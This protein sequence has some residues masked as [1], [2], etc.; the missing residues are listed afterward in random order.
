[1]RIKLDE[2]LPQRLDPA[3]ASLGHEVDTVVRE[4]LQGSE[5]ETLWPEVQA[6]R[7]FL[8]TTDLDFSDERRFPPGTHAGILVLRLSDD[9]SQA[10]TERLAAVFA[11]ES[12]ETWSGCLVI[13]TD[14]KVRVRRPQPRASS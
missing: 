10:V 6:A 9:R 12:V 7:R 3:L 4:G 8:I 13:V 11:S 1:M 2:N 5:D 14:H